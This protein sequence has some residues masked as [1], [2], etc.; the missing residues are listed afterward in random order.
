MDLATPPDVLVVGDGI[1]G[2]TAAITAHAAGAKV[3]VIDKAP[4]DVP[5]GNTA[6]SGGNL[7]RIS[8]QYPAERFYDDMLR[9]S[10]NRADTE[11][12]RIIV[13]DSAKAC[14]WLATLGVP[15]V[16]IAR[17][18][19]FANRA[20]GRGFGLAAAL[21]RAVRMHSIP[22]LNEVEA[23]KLLQE[24]GGVVG[25]RVREKS[26]EEQDIRAAA[27]V[28]AT[29]GFGANPEMVKKYIGPGATNLVL[30]G[31]TFDTGDGLRMAEAVGAKLDW[32]DDF[33]GGLIHY[34]YR[35]Y[36]QE[37]ATKGMRSVKLYEACVLINKEGRRFIDEGEN[38]ADKTYAKFGKV[39]ALTQPD[40]IAYAVGDARS[41]N[42]I[43]VI[44]S[45]PER[46]PVEAETLQ[47]L[48]ALIEV[49]VSTFVATLTEFN[50][51]VTGDKAL[52][53]T[54]PKS[55]FAQKIDTAPFYAYKLTGGFTFTFGGLRAKKTGEV[56]DVHQQ[57]IPGLYAV[58]EIVTGVF[59]GNYAAGSS[60]TRCAV[61]GRIVGFEAAHH[62][63]PDLT[64]PR[65]LWPAG[66]P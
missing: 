16:T 51:N 35:K 4:A 11:I 62:A 14:D 37:G 31:S 29:G 52:G 19:A 59:F 48:A 38:T 3:L 60:L 1:A 55:H 5:H 33:H 32:M 21:R 6:F 65:D 8:E 39:I 63:R 24:N 54:P 43:D 22:I 25:V 53:L 13:E 27:V 36:P 20:D 58:G 50:A 49:P 28:I 66:A 47:D 15:W 44:Y 17:T 46:E 42:R 30:R 18:A 9:V 34:G 57:I 12:A 2:C 10:E 41:R 23:L 64:I 26:G 61:F 56:L 7:R 45:G 40:G